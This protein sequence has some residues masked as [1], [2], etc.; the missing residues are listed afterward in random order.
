MVTNR[1]RKSSGS[2]KKFQMLLRRLAQLTFFIGVQAFRDP[3]GGELLDVQIFMNDGPNP[4][5]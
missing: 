3:L 5:T 1:E 2:H 4:I